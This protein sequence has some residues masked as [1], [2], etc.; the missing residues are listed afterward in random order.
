MPLRV[1]ARTFAADHACRETVHAVHHQEVGEPARDQP[2]D[3]APVHVHP[4]DISN[5]RPVAD[6]EGGR[7][8]EARRIAQ[9]P[10]HQ[11][12]KSAMAM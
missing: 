3:E 1:A 10:F 7:L 11:W 12:L 5:G 9:R 8:V 4:R 6:G 2:E